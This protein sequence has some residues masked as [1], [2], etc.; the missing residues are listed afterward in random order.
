MSWG[1]RHPV[2]DSILALTIVGTTICAFIWLFH[3]R[4]TPEQIEADRGSMAE[5]SAQAKERSDEQ[6]RKIYTDSLAK[7]GEFKEAFKDC[8][9]LQRKYHLEGSPA[10][11]ARRE[12][13]RQVEEGVTAPGR[14][15]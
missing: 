3:D 12:I 13:A 5:N 9:A 10:T 14:P 1:E 6:D 8:Q 4:R 11:C 7:P 2:L 15:D